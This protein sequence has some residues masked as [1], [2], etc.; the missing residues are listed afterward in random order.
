[1]ADH[2]LDGVLHVALGHPRELHVE[3]GEFQLA[4]GA[5]G[6]VAEAARD[7]VVTVEA[8]H[9]QD[10]L[11]QLRALRQ[12]VELARMHARRDQKSRA[13]FGRGLGQDRRLDVLEAAHPR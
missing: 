11:E 12:G 10:L 13:P 5:Q 4:V 1:M 3:L 6:F 9:H 8:R 7:L 2:R